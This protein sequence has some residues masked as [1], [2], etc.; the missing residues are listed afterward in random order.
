MTQQLEQQIVDLQLDINYHLRA[1]A[2]AQRRVQE[3]FRLNGLTGAYRLG[4]IE[5]KPEKKEGEQ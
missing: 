2:E 5:D 3:L 1:A 4:V